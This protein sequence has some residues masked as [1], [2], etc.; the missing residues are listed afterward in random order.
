M[1]CISILHLFLLKILISTHRCLPSILN[2]VVFPSGQHSIMTARNHIPLPSLS[3]CRNQGK[4]SCLQFSS[5]KKAYLIYLCGS[6]KIY[7]LS[8]IRA[9]SIEECMACVSCWGFFFCYII[10]GYFN[11]SQHLCYYSFAK[12][13]GFF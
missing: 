3:S 7:K 5:L 4:N 10:V 6:G 8:A 11:C 12:I 9:G 13:S 2:C 1:V